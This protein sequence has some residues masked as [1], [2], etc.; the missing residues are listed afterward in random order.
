MNGIFPFSH[1]LLTPLVFALTVDFP[2]PS[3]LR[4]RPWQFGARQHM[5]VGL[6]A[7]T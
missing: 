6:Q 7:H 3:T 4:N 2:I 1:F 5:L